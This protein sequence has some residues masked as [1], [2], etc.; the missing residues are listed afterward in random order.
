MVIHTFVKQG[1]KGNFDTLC[2]HVVPQDIFS[3]VW[4]ETKEDAFL[5][6]KLKL[7]R[8]RARRANPNA[9]TKG[10]KSGKVRFDVVQRRSGE[11]AWSFKGRAFFMRR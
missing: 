1:M 2:F 5:S 11:L 3:G 6:V 7:A 4:Q 10:A 9:T 8:A